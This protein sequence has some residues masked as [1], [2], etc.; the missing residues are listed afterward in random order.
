MA[1][2]V[3]EQQFRSGGRAAVRKLTSDDLQAPLDE[4]PRQFTRAETLHVDQSTVARRLHEMGKIQKA[5]RW[6]PQTWK[7]AKAPVPLC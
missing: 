6:V 7:I 5:G 1:C 3:P 4:H 2:Q